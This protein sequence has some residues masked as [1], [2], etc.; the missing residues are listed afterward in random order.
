MRLILSDQNSDMPLVYHSDEG[1]RVYHLIITNTV[2]SQI[3][4]FT[5]E[6][7]ITLPFF[8]PKEH[9]FGMVGH[10]N[11]VVKK[12]LGLSTTVL[13]CV[14]FQY[15]ININRVDA[16]YILE[17]HTLGWTPSYGG[18]WIDAAMANTLQ[19]EMCEHKDIIL[20][21]FDNCSQDVSDDRRP[22]AKIGW[23]DTASEWIKD[24]LN[25]IGISKNIQI[26]QVRTWER[27]CILK[28]VAG[29]QCFFFKAIPSR[30]AH[31]IPISKLIAERFPLNAIHLIAV[32]SAYHWMLMEE[33]QG[34]LLH[35]VSDITL[36]QKALYKYA[37]IQIDSINIIDQ[38][39]TAGC[40]DFTPKRMV[41]YIDELFDDTEVMLLDQP[42]GLS[43][44]EFNALRSLTPSIKSLLDE[45]GESQILDT[46]SHGDFWA[47]NVVCSS[48]N[49][50]IFDWSDSSI[51]HPFFDL[52]FFFGMDKLPF[53]EH[54]QDAL[55]DTYLAPWTA[56]E[57]PDRLITLSSYAKRLGW[58]H[59]AIIEHQL[60]LRGI[61]E[62]AKWEFQNALP[63]YLRRVLIEWVICA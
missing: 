56:Y 4:V 18:Y 10:I 46:L 35:H 21:W 33:Y 16:V 47:G 32:D 17:D 49:V 37:Q 14:S 42:G 44:D 53:N 39:I 9:H 24:Q 40:P 52:P 51:T 22:W 27:S 38:L 48:G 36:W 50:L 28:A 57:N 45:L 11:K 15:D 61:E 58:I 3:L 29:S 19:M 20:G 30:F 62:S 8:E 1:T 6:N 34:T 43:G 41:T 55:R 13:R 23:F 2:R 25:Q 12:N 59:K 63:Y 26:E 7:G 60:V 54:E 31:E 5:D